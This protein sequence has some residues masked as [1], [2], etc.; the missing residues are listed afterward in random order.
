MTCFMQGL[1]ITTE[2]LRKLATK[3]ELAFIMGH[4]LTHLLE[5]HTDM[6]TDEKSAAQGWWSRQPNEVVMD[7]WCSKFTR[8][9]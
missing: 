2:M 3:D 4:E 6:A 7:F 9:C 5:G 1:R 8:A